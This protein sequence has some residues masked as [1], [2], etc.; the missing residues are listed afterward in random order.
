MV[1]PVSGASQAYPGNTH[2]ED[3]FRKPFLIIHEGS[4]YRK[5]WIDWAFKVKPPETLPHFLPH[6]Y[7]DLKG[8]HLDIGLQ[9]LPN[10]IGHSHMHLYYWLEAF[11]PHLEK[12]DVKQALHVYMSHPVNLAQLFYLIGTRHSPIAFA[13]I[14]SKNMT[15]MKAILHFL[16]KEDHSQYYYFFWDLLSAT[17]HGGE[18]ASFAISDLHYAPDEKSLMR[19]LLNLRKNDPDLAYAMAKESM[20][21]GGRELGKYLE[22]LYDNEFDLSYFRQNFSINFL[23]TTVIRHDIY[24]E[25]V[26]HTSADPFEYYYH[27]DCLRYLTSLFNF[28]SKRFLS[29]EFI[30]FLVKKR[31]RAEHVPMLW[32]HRDMACLFIKLHHDWKEKL[33]QWC[34][35]ASQIP[36]E[37]TQTGYWQEIIENSPSHL[38]ERFINVQREKL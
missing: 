13:F 24:F 26:Y 21:N 22:D 16:R 35:T 18:A 15:F 8:E 10:L 31:I 17:P 6:I 34:E 2:F 37:L 1:S 36:F 9:I 25:L 7:G 14:Q 38:K 29:D 3:I 20:P 5:K 11:W 4:D 12:P 19:F 30:T 27:D 28:L 32:G 23:K 33:Y